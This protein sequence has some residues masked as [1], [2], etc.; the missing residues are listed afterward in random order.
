MDEKPIKGDFTETTEDLTEEVEVELEVEKREDPTERF[1]QAKEDLEDLLSKGEVIKKVIALD[2]INGLTLTFNGCPLVYSIRQLQED[3]KTYFQE[4]RKVHE[5]CAHFLKQAVSKSKLV[6]PNP[7]ALSIIYWTILGKTALVNK[8]Y[9]ASVEVA[10]YNV[11]SEGVQLGNH[12]FKNFP[13]YIT[14]EKEKYE[15]LFD[16]YLSTEETKRDHAVLLEQTALIRNLSSFVRDNK[17]VQ[18][19]VLGNYLNQI[20]PAE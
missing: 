5:R 8:I 13:E 10:L 7:A 14:P 12:F 4:Q 17:E 19:V 18:L 3:P 20:Y 2:K 15:T 11:F 9:L 6:N 16:H 1:M